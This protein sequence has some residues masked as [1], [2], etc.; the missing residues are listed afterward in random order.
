MILGK[1]GAMLVLET[2]QGARK[3]E[4]RKFTARSSA[5]VCRPDASHITQPSSSGA[6]RAMRGAR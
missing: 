4:G 5:S 2:L 3:T 6:A 1:G